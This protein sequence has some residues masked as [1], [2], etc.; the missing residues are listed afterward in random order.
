MDLRFAG[1]KD[2]S[3]AWWRR[4][5]PS[6]AMEISE[7]ERQKELEMW[8]EFRRKKED[9]DLVGRCLG[10]VSLDTYMIIYGYLKKNRGGKLPPK[11]SILIGFSLIFTIHFGV[12]LFLETPIYEK[13]GGGKLLEIGVKVMK[14]FS[15][16]IADVV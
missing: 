13:E 12:A 3:L 15:L 8:D 1:T 9:L 16:R 11:S 2:E 10:V 14:R 6:D 4:G 5:P 7:L